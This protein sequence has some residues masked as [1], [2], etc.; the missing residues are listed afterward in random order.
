MDNKLINRFKSLAA[1]G[2]LSQL[3]EQN[4]TFNIKAP[5]LSGE[6]FWDSY[7]SNGWKLQINIISGWWRIVDA[8]DVRVARGT[9]ERQLKALLDNRPTSPL[10]NY[11]DEAFALARHRLGRR[12]ATQWC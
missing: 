10:P 4:S 1:S 12:L 8:N 11:M 7:E 6:V 9:T 3:I 5:I 2:E